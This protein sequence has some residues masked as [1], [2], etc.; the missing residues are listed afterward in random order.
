MET[1]IMAEPALVLSHA[2]AAV[3]AR[4]NPGG[5]RTATP[6]RQRCRADAAPDQVDAA[7]QASGEADNTADYTGFS[8]VGVAG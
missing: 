4:A 5:R 6:L 2:S 8:M 3:S 1:I 7:P